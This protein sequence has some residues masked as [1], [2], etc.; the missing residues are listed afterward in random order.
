MSFESMNKLAE[1]SNRSMVV[2]GSFTI[3]TTEEGLVKLFNDF[4]I[5]AGKQVYQ[6]KVEF[7]DFLSSIVFGDNPMSL[8]LSSLFNPSK[9]SEVFPIYTKAMSMYKEYK[10]TGEVAGACYDVYY[11]S[12]VVSDY[13]QMYPELMER[14]VAT[15]SDKYLIYFVFHS[16]DDK[17]SREDVELMVHTMESNYPYSH[18]HAALSF[19][20][21]YSHYGFKN[22]LNMESLSLMWEFTLKTGTDL[23]YKFLRK[24]RNIGSAAYCE[25]LSSFIESIKAYMVFHKDVHIFV[26]SKYMIWDELSISNSEYY[27]K[28]KSGLLAPYMYTSLVVYYLYSLLYI[29]PVS[30]DIF[31][32]SSED[33]KNLLKQREVVER[34]Q[35]MYVFG[36]Y[37]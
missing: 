17:Y 14:L 34:M 32:D 26:P 6:D 12:S 33:I 28:N 23:C 9:F 29:R 2:N 18:K 4:G 15:V 21:M 13:M 36:E 19:I 1:A 24:C 27:S 7:D 3:P 31:Y 5:W 20:H 22:N 25:Q 35:S 37:L 11:S 10:D 16:N 30:N 8:V